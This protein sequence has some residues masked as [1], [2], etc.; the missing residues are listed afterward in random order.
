MKEAILYEKIDGGK[1]RCGL[2][3]HHCVI[4]PGK[5]G[6]C[7]VRE[8]RGG[9]LYSLN[10]GKACSMAIDPIEKKP[11]YHW[12]P[13]TRVFSFSTVGCNF[14]CKGCQNWEISQ[15]SEILGHE[16]PPEEI[17]RLCTSNKVEG[18]AY[19]YTEPTVFMEY[20]LDTAKLAKKL[21]LYNVFVTN[22]YMSPEAIRKMG[23]IDASRIDLKFMNDAH[24]ATYCS[25]PNGV[26]CVTR[27][28]KLLHKKGHIEII[29]LVIP[30][31]N[32]S[33][34]DFHAISKFVAGLDKD[35]PLHFSAFSPQYKAVGLQSTAVQVLDKAVKIAHDEGIRHVYVGNVPGHKNEHTYCP[36]CGKI[37]IRR[38]GFGVMEFNLDNASKCLN[39]GTKL[40]IIAFRHDG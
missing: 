34:D 11:F 9:T 3:N 16:L 1:V 40:K 17:M 18:I 19:T 36:K 12:F 21:G 4:S 14:H 6:F 30:S 32:D 5:R 31:L 37:V 22:G 7:R 2:C 25:A 20:A 29:N 13:G 8:N 38:H 24:Y 35:V 28:I 26:E 39:C 33:E 15:T 23:D 27:S 10:Y